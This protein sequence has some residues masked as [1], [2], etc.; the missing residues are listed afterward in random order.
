[1]KEILK[2]LNKNI[3]QISISEWLF[4]KDTLKMSI[5]IAYLNNDKDTINILLENVFVK[6]LCKDLKNKNIENI[7]KM[8]KTK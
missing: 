6:Y 7:L 4:I 8:C 1:M 2:S 3:S 5:R